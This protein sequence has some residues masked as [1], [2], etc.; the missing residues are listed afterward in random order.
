MLL[1]DA[2]RRLG[3]QLNE[4]GAQMTKRRLELTAPR[5]GEMAR[6]TVSA[7]PVSSMLLTASAVVAGAYIVSR[8]FGRE[9]SMRMRG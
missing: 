4:L 3:K 8:A 2:E 7:M 6:D 1:P 5:L 9:S